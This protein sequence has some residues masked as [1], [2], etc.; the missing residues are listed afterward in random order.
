MSVVLQTD[1]QRRTDRKTNERNFRTE[2]NDGRDA[3][4]NE[5]KLWRRRMWCVLGMS[6]NGRWLWLV[7]WTDEREKAPLRSFF[8]SGS[9]AD[10]R[11]EWRPWISQMSVRKE[12][13]AE[14]KS[15]CNASVRRMIRHIS[16]PFLFPFW[17]LC[18]R[19]F[20]AK[21]SIGVNVNG[22]SVGSI[23]GRF[24]LDGIVQNIL[25]IK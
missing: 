13:T 19:I 11:T 3:E 14:R 15:L 5:H 8:V 12:W 6:E 23:G 2:S 10:R 20:S 7:C 1:R 21:L 4:Q 18:D 9:L 24:L 17:L 22:H 25:C 16:S